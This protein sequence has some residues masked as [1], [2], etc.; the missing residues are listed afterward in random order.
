MT[1]TLEKISKEA[2]QKAYDEAPG[3]GIDNY[4]SNLAWEIYAK[5]IVSQ[6]ISQIVKVSDRHTDQY[7][8][9]ALRDAVWEIEEH[10]G[11]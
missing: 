8:D 9:A 7:I 4:R 6:C 11:L 3:E 1:P 5:M 2:W 10:F